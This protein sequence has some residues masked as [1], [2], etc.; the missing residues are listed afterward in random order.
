MLSSTAALQ[1]RNNDEEHLPEGSG[2]VQPSARGE[3][4]RSYG[5]DSSKGATQAKG[6]A[7]CANPARGAKRSARSQVQD[8]GNQGQ[9]GRF[10]SWIGTMALATSAALHLTTTRPKSR[11]APAP[12]SSPTRPPAAYPPTMRWNRMNSGS[13]D[14]NERGFQWGAPTER[15]LGTRSSASGPA[16]ESTG[17]RGGGLP[18]Y[19]LTTENQEL[20]GMYYDNAGFLGRTVSVWSAITWTATRVPGG[21][22]RGGGGG[23]PMT[24]I[25]IFQSSAR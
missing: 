3:E 21:R 7:H 5:S 2:Q 14:S 20:A 24:P 18:L 17:R 16:P 4:L 9:F 22:D 13:Q 8:Q 25:R 15:A 12:R 10:L 6:M 1:M 11:A 19:G 23:G